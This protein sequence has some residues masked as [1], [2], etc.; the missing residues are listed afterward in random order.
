MSSYDN[1]NIGKEEIDRTAR[2]NMEVCA[3]FVARMIQKYGHEVL[4]EIEEMRA[5]E[6][7]REQ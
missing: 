4:T 7:T 1:V 2:I 3:A 5:N 6:N